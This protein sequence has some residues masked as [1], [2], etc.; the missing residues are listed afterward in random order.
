MNIPI[1]KTYNYEKSRQTEPIHDCIRS[2][3]T[4]NKLSLTWNSSVNYA[5][6]LNNFTYNSTNKTATLIPPNFK[7]IVI[8]Y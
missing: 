1:V 5:N 4:F 6:A 7:H 3:E 8:A 2:C